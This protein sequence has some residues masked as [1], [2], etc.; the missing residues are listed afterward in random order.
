MP[1]KNDDPTFD[2]PGA[3]DQPSQQSS[4]N[5][6]TSSIPR[7]HNPQA[8]VAHQPIKHNAVVNHPNHPEFAPEGE[9]KSEL[10]HESK[11]QVIDHTTQPHSQQQIPLDP[12]DPKKVEAKV[13]L[14]KLRKHKHFKTARFAIV[15]FVVFLLLFNFQFMYSQV[16]YWLTPKQ[17]ASTQTIVPNPTTPVTPVVS[18][19][20]AE[21][22]GP[23]N[24][25]I[26]P[27]INVNAPLVFIDTLEEQKILTALQ[28]GVVHYAGTAN[29]GENGNS[30]IFGHSSNDWWE[31]GNYKFVFVLLEKLV[32]G[33]QYEIHYQSRRYVYQV[34]STKVV[35]PTDLTVLDQTPTP[36]STLITCTPP[37][38][39]WRRF[40][41]K[42]KQ[43]A[44]VPAI[45]TQE[46]AHREPSATTNQPSVLPSAPP[47]VFEQ[48]RISITSFFNGVF[49]NKS[50]D[51]SKPTNQ[52]N[53]P[54]NHLP[55]V[56]SKPSM[57]TIF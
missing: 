9:K 51:Q 21:V 4:S 22:V 14:E 19:T 57:P 39:S 7:F 17:P 48:L 26:I 23:E 43:I 41:V 20:P 55:E 15:S 37:G 11:P 47:S 3:S 40:I 6:D 24:V 38:T 8:N 46:V 53:Q 5:L 30:V 16:T 25:L 12:I 34:E 10:L 29:P 33:D 2:I 49:G 56:T 28:G 54:V 18:P 35:Q 52:Q 1:P 44:P 32:P 42:A 50:T 31:K 13:K 27:K 36:Y 45:P